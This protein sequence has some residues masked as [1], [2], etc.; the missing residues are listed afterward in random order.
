MI[1]RPLLARALTAFLP[2]V[3]CELQYG[4]ELSRPQVPRLGFTPLSRTG[5]FRGV[6]VTKWGL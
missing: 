6:N 4:A 3:P 2:A 5:P 1:D